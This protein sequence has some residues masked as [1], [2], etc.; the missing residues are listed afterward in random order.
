MTV[1]AAEFQDYRQEDRSEPVGQGSFLEHAKP[2]FY[3]FQPP[4]TRDDWVG[5]GKLMG[6]RPLNS[7]VGGRNMYELGYRP[8]FGQNQ[9]APWM[10][11]DYVN[12]SVSR[13]G[14]VDVQGRAKGKGKERM[15][16]LDE[17][18]WEAEFMQMDTQG[19]DGGMTADAKTVADQAKDDIKWSASETLEGGD[20]DG[21]WNGIQAE[22]ADMRGLMSNDLETTRAFQRGGGGADADLL[23]RWDQFDGVGTHGGWSNDSPS[24]GYLFEEDNP[25]L[26]VA[27]DAFAEGVRIMEEGGNLSLAALAFEAA[28]QKHPEHVEAWTRLG[29]AQAQNEK[30]TPAIR[31]LEQALRLDPSDLSALMGLAVSCTNE[32]Y[33]SMAYQSLERWLST[34]YPDVLDPGAM[35]AIPEFGF[36]DRHQLHERVTKLFIRAAQLSPD[37]EHMDPDVQVGLGVLFYAAEEFEKAVDCFAA[38]LASSEAGTNTRREQVHLLWNRLGATLANSGRSED[39]IAAYERALALRPNFVRARYNLGVA[40][41]NM[42]CFPQAAQHLLAALDMHRLVEL[43]GRQRARNILSRNHRSSSSSAPAPPAEANEDEINQMMRRLDLRPAAAFS[44]AQNQSTNLYDTLR[45]VFTQMSRR[46]LLNRVGPG[47]DLDALRAEFDF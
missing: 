32:G 8:G 31:A 10:L 11:S 26:D 22:M 7:V 42:H 1:W 18:D 12:L 28:V 37:G 43:D 40:C 47:M 36:L 17:A 46:D 24:V 23:D 13:P 35:S 30:E 38:A 25:F 33:D 3:H 21:L 14:G 39:A 27:P 41:I 29:N 5:G 15:R 16:E 45:R 6:A 4:L 19:Q 34:K 2:V 20:L 44:I 9:S